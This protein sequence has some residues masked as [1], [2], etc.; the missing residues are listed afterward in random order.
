MLREEAGRTRQIRGS[1][2]AKPAQ[3]VPPP[4]QVWH[5]G[6]TDGWAIFRCRSRWRSQPREDVVEARPADLLHLGADADD[7]AR[8]R[9]QAAEVDSGPREHDIAPHRFDRSPEGGELIWA[10]SHGGQDGPEG[11]IRVEHRPLTAARVRT[12]IGRGAPPLRA[13]RS[14]A[15]AG[16]P[17]C[18]SVG[19][20][21][22]EVPSELGGLVEP[23]AEDQPSAGLVKPVDPRDTGTGKAFAVAV[24]RSRIA[25]TSRFRGQLPGDLVELTRGRCGPGR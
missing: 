7:R 1:K 8:Q 3:G 5:R 2:G 24:I 15:P 22:T 20:S 16:I 12:G 9:E 4:P 11:R 21:S 13:A 10:V 25:S 6:P 23:P 17:P 19:T 14:A 18:V